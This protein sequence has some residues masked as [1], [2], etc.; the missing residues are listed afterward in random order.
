MQIL[1]KY[2]IKDEPAVT[3]ASRSKKPAP[4]KTR[5]SKSVEDP[6]IDSD[7]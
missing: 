3:R 7:S 1:D 6:A 2:G 4:K 5:L